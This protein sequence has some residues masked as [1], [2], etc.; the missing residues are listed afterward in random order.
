LS[1]LATCEAQLKML[2][3]RCFSPPPRKCQ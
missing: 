2:Q 1:Q 3:A